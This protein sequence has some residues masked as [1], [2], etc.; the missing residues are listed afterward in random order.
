MGY[1]LVTASNG[2]LRNTVTT[3]WHFY[4]LKSVTYSILVSFSGLLDCSGHVICVLILKKSKDYKLLHFSLSL[5]SKACLNVRTLVLNE[6]LSSSGSLL[7]TW[8]SFPALFFC[9]AG[10]LGQ[11][12]TAQKTGT[13]KKTR[14]KAPWVSIKVLALSLDIIYISYL[15][16]YVA[17]TLI[18]LKSQNLAW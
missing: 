17:F 4:Y 2:P 15:A 3:T 12:C 11:K 18:P 6:L 10:V 7:T 8:G 9:L 1:R 16:L 13:W 14:Q 5:T